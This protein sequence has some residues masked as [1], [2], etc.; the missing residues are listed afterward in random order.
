MINRGK[1]PKLNDSASM[2]G[3]MAGKT[4]RKVFWCFLQIGPFPNKY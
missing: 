4:E 1:M 2:F 3:F